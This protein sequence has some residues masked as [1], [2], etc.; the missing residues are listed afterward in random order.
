MMTHGA[1]ADSETDLSLESKH[2]VD[3]FIK[4]SNLIQASDLNGPMTDSC[5]AL[6]EVRPEAIR[7]SRSEKSRIRIFEIDPLRDPRWRAFLEIRTDASLFHRVEWLQALKSCYGYEPR[8]LSL[9]PQGEP[10]TNALLF[11][12]VRSPLTG[13]R[14]VSVPFSDHC[15]P[16]VNGAEELQQLLQGLSER[17]D[18]GRWKYFEFRPIVS[19]PVSTNSFAISNE[20]FLHRLDLRHSEE[21]LFHG[22]HKNSVQR[23]LRRA[24]RESLRYQEGSSEVLLEHF[25]NLLIMTRRRQGVPPQPLK[26]FRSL[27]SSI[28]PSLKIRVA[29]K[30]ETPVASILTISDKRTMVYKYGCSDPSF[31]NLGGTPLLFWRAIQE[32]RANGME[33]FDMGRSETSN[34]G[35][36]RFK[37]HWGAKRIPLNYWRYP[38]RAAGLGPERA[39]RYVRKLIS[40]TPDKPLVLLGSLLYP[41]IG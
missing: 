36:I 17:V 32:A 14:V 26:W 28:G 24:E 6:D 23:K 19:V 25:Y 7:E 22:F 30:G 16:L 27:I 8:V 18:R 40:I 37:E 29:L 41:H 31:A 4:D 33:Q 21:E 10:L 2:S 12:Q 35:L 9:S 1:C 15:E 13:R 3:M 5:L 11:C 38:A 20:Y 39:I 34:E